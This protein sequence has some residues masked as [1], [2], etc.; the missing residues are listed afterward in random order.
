[1]VLT[2]KSTFGRHFVGKHPLF[3]KQETD[4]GIWWEKNIFYLWWSFLRLHEGYKKT[5]SRKGA[6]TYSKLYADFGDVHATDFKTWWTS[7]APDGGSR[8]A[9][10]FAEPYSPE[11]VMALTNEEALDLI[12]NDRDESILLVAI[13]LKFRRREITTALHKIISANHGRKRG[14]KRVKGSLA[15]YKLDKAFKADGLKHVLMV[16]EERRKNPKKPL[17][18]IA[19]DVG[20]GPKF[21]PSEQLE[22]EKHKLTH[23]RLPKSYSSNKAS[24]T[25][26]ASRM[27]R[28]AEII[29]ENVGS[30][31]FPVTR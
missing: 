10:L 21:S 22:Y 18:E 30:G 2:N 15:K 24:L 8:G 28:L 4:K 31:K 16:Y 23:R 11:K 25:S 26:A 5:C 7:K 20:V 6:G 17:F 9:Y 19:L 14:Q 1:M 29:I 3:R 13:P 27:L 12:G